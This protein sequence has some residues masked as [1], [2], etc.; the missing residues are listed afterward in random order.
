MAE[1]ELDEREAVYEAVL[2]AVRGGEPACLLTIIETH[3]STPREV[4]TKMLLRSDGTTAGTIGGGKIE[5]TALADA[6]EA[7][8][9]CESRISYYSLL[10]ESKTDLGVC[11]G[12]ARVFVEVLH[13]KPTLLIAGAGHVGQPLATFGHLLGFR[14]VVADDRQEFANPQRLTTADSL[15][16]GPYEE[17]GKRVSINARTYIVIATRGHEYDETVLRQVLDSPAAYIGM[18]GSRSKVRSVFDR[19]L[20]DGI[21]RAKLARVCAP[22]GLRTNGQTPAEIALSIMAEIVAVQHGGTG[23]PMSLRDNPLR[24]DDGKPPAGECC[25]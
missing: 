1:G 13:P 6:R 14:T 8:A 9:A 15:V 23:E 2:E 22:V 20:A 12:D 18:I 5:A 7:L 25:S 11:G 4:G 19:L 24:S 3:G 10:G 21:P 17:L 16:V